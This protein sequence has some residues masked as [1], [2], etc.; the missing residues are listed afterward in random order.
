MAD[1]F[2]PP[3]VGASALEVFHE[4]VRITGYQ[5]E[6]EKRLAFVR[7]A[8]RLPQVVADEMRVT[9]QRLGCLSYPMDEE[10]LFV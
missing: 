1:D 10:R 8:G 6:H 5:L 7:Q 4:G 9:G 3:Q 2:G